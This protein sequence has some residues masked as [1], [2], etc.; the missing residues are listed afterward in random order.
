MYHHFMFYMKYV[1][2]TK[3]LEAAMILSEIPSPNKEPDTQMLPEAKQET[4]SQPEPVFV[5]TPKDRLVVA[6]VSLVVLVFCAVMMYDA[7]S[8]L[9]TGTIGW[10]AT[11]AVILFAVVTINVVMFLSSSHLKRI[12]ERSRL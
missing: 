6:I 4:W 10:L 5:P 2:S 8:I 9:H 12:N 3:N 11:L 7:T 1:S